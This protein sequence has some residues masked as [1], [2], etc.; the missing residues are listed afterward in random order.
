MKTLF[1]IWYIF[2]HPEIKSVYFTDDAIDSDN[3][4]TPIQAVEKLSAYWD[5]DERTKWKINR[6]ENDLVIY[7]QD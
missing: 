2:Q 5:V 1:L 7:I 4:L 6:I 3:G